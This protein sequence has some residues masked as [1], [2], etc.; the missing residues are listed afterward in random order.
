MKTPNLGTV[1][2]APSDPPTDTA[3]I[4]RF[5]R[6]ELDKI[7]GAITALAAGHLDQT[8]VAPTKPRDGDIR[9]ADGTL[10]KP[11]GTGAV[12]VYYYKSSTSTW[13]LLG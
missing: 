10:W 13:V 5:L 2:Y 1:F 8:T 3:E 11:N 9:Y 12:G 7:A 4:A 6:Q